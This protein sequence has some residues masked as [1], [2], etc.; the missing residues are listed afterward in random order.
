M[1]N[2]T[3]RELFNRYRP[4]R[5]PSHLEQLSNALSIPSVSCGKGRI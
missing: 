2:R 1:K 4:D 5:N 3:D